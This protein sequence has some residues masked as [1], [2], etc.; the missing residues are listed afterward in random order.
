MV[1]VTIK[2]GPVVFFSI[3]YYPRVSDCGGYSFFLLGLYIDLDLAKETWF[4]TR[5]VDKFRR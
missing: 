1:N 5:H 2:A 3:Y 4:F